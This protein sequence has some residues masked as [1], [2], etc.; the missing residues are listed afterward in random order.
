MLESPTSNLFMLEEKLPARVPAY[1]ESFGR[2]ARASKIFLLAITS[3]WV[4]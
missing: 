1:A 4:H 2:Q 3:Q